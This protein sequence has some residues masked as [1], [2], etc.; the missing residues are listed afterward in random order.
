[1]GGIG[2]LTLLILVITAYCN[3]K[4]EF[5]SQTLVLSSQSCSNM[6]TVVIDTSKIHENLSDGFNY[7]LVMRIEN[8]FPSVEHTPNNVQFQTFLTYGMAH[9]YHKSSKS[10]LYNVSFAPWNYDKIELRQQFPR[11]NVTSPGD[12]PDLRLTVLM[13]GEGVTRDV[14]CNTLLR[15]S[16]DYE[17]YSLVKEAQQF[18]VDEKM[19]KKVCEIRC[20]FSNP[21]RIVVQQLLAPNLHDVRDTIHLSEFIGITHQ[22]VIFPCAALGQG[23][24]KA[25]A[26]NNTH[27]VQLEVTSYSPYILEDKGIIEFESKVVF[28]RKPKCDGCYLVFENNYH[29]FFYFDNIRAQPNNLKY[30]QLKNPQHQL[31]YFGTEG[32]FLI[33]YFEGVSLYFD[34]FNDDD[35]DLHAFNNQVN[36][37]SNVVSVHPI[38]TDGLGRAFLRVVVPPLVRPYDTFLKLDITH[39]ERMIISSTSVFFL[40]EK[41][42]KLK[43]LSLFQEEH[44]LFLNMCFSMANKESTVLLLIDNAQEFS[45]TL[46]ISFLLDSI[47]TLIVNEEKCSFFYDVGEEALFKVK[48]GDLSKYTEIKVR[49]DAYED[50]DSDLL[51]DFDIQFGIDKPI[52]GDSSC[53]KQYDIDSYTE[54]QVYGGITKT[55]ENNIFVIGISSDVIRSNSDVE[56]YITVRSKNLMMDHHVTV[57]MFMTEFMSEFVSISTVSKTLQEHSVFISQASGLFTTKHAS[58]EL[59][60]PFCDGNEKNRYEKCLKKNFGTT[61]PSYDMLKVNIKIDIPENSETPP[62]FIATW[63][64][65]KSVDTYENKAA[66]FGDGYTKLIGKTEKYEADIIVPYCAYKRFDRLSIFSDFSG[67]SFSANFTVSYQTVSPIKHVTKDSPIKLGY[68][69]I[70]LNVKTEKFREKVGLSI[71]N[72]CYN[73]LELH[74]VRFIDNLYYTVSMSPQSLCEATHNYRLTDRLS[75]VTDSDGSDVKFAVFPKQSYMTDTSGTTEFIAHLMLSNARLCPSSLEVDLPIRLV[76]N[77]ETLI[78]LLITPVLNSHDDACAISFR[79]RNIIADKN[80]PSLRVF[81]TLQQGFLPPGDVGPFSALFDMENSFEYP[82]TDSVRIIYDYSE[83]FWLS[84]RVLNNEDDGFEARNL[85]LYEVDVLHQSLSVFHHS[86]Q[87]NLTNIEPGEEISVFTLD[88]TTSAATFYFSEVPNNFPGARVTVTCASSPMNVIVEWKSNEEPYSTIFR[89]RNTFQYP[90]FR[91]D[92][93]SFAFDVVQKLNTGPQTMRFVNSG[94]DHHTCLFSLTMLERQRKLE[95]TALTHV[96][97]YFS[98]NAGLLRTGFYDIEFSFNDDFFDE[99]VLMAAIYTDTYLKWEEIAVDPIKNHVSFTN[100][101]IYEKDELTEVTLILC[102]KESYGSH[103]M[104]MKSSYYDLDAAKLS[105][106]YR[107]NIHATVVLGLNYELKCP[108]KPSLFSYMKVSFRDLRFKMDKFDVSLSMGGSQYSYAFNYEFD[109]QHNQIQLDISYGNYYLLLINYPYYMLHD[110]SIS[111]ECSDTVRVNVHDGTETDHLLKSVIA[112]ELDN[113][114]NEEIVQVFELNFEKDSNYDYSNIYYAVYDSCVGN[115]TYSDYNMFKPLNS[116]QSHIFL[117]LYRKH[118]DTK[119]VVLVGCFNFTICNHNLRLYIRQSPF[120][121][122]I[123]DLSFVKES[124]TKKI[125]LRRDAFV[126]H[127]F[128]STGHLTNTNVR[129]FSNRV[130][131][132]HTRSCAHVDPIDVSLL[133]R[134]MWQYYSDDHGLRCY[135]SCDHSIV[136]V[137]AEQPHDF[138]GVN[139]PGVCPFGHIDSDGEEHA[140]CEAVWFSFEDFGIFDVSQDEIT[141]EVQFFNDSIISNTIV[142]TQMIDRGRFTIASNTDASLIFHYST[143]YP[144]V[145]YIDTLGFDCI[146]PKHRLSY[147]RNEMLTATSFNSSKKYVPTSSGFLANVHVNETE[148]TEIEVEI[149]HNFRAPAYT[150]RF[151]RNYVLILTRRIDFVFILDFR[152]AALFTM[153]LPS[154][155]SKCTVLVKLNGEI[156]FPVIPMFDIDSQVALYGDTG[157]MWVFEFIPS[158]PC[159]SLPITYSFKEKTEVKVLQIGQLVDCIGNTCLLE[160]DTAHLLPIESLRLMFLRH[161]FEDKQ[162][163][164]FTVQIS[165][166]DFCDS[167]DG[168]TPFFVYGGKSTSCEVIHSIRST[169]NLEDFSVYPSLKLIREQFDYITGSDAGIEKKIYMLV[170]NIKFHFDKFNYF[171][172][173]FYNIKEEYFWN[174]NNAFY[175]LVYYFSNIPGYVFI[176]RL[177]LDNNHLD[178]IYFVACTNVYNIDQFLSIYNS[179]IFTKQNKYIQQDRSVKCY[180]G[181]QATLQKNFDRTDPRNDAG[182][183]KNR[184]VFSIREGF[185][186]HA[187]QVSIYLLVDDDVNSQISFKYSVQVR[188]SLG[189]IN[190]VKENYIFVEL[191]QFRTRK[192]HLKDFY[193]PLGLYNLFVDI[194]DNDQLNWSLNITDK[195]FDQS[196]KQL[197]LACIDPD[198]YIGFFAYQCWPKRIDADSDYNRFFS[199][200]D[201]FCYLRLS[202]LPSNDMLLLSGKRARTDI[203]AL[204]VKSDFDAFQRITYIIDLVDI[205]SDTINLFFHEKFPGLDVETCHRHNYAALTTKILNDVIFVTMIADQVGLYFTVDGAMNA[206]VNRVGNNISKIDEKDHVQPMYVSSHIT[207]VFPSMGDSCDILSYNFANIMNH[208]VLKAFHKDPNVEYYDITYFTNESL[209]PNK[210]KEWKGS[211]KTVEMCVSNNKCDVT[212]FW[213]VCS[214][215]EKANV[216]SLKVNFEYKEF[217]EIDKINAG[218]GSFSMDSQ[219]VALLPIEFGKDLCHIVTVECEGDC[220]DNVMMLTLDDDTDQRFEKTSLSLTE[221]VGFTG[222]AFCRTQSEVFKLKKALYFTNT[223]CQVNVSTIKTERESSG[224]TNWLE[225]LNWSMELIEI[226]PQS[227]YTVSLKGKGSAVVTLIPM[228]SAFTHRTIDNRGIFQL[229][230]KECDGLCFERTVG[231]K[232]SDTY[233]IVVFFKGSFKISMEDSQSIVLPSVIRK[234]LC[235]TILERLQKY[236]IKHLEV[237][238]VTH[239]FFSFDQGIESVINRKDALKELIMSV[240]GCPIVSEE[241]VGVL[242]EYSCLI[243]FKP[244]TYKN[245]FSALP[246]FLCLEMRD[247][248]HGVNEMLGLDCN[249]SAFV[250]YDLVLMKAS[251]IWIYVVAFILIVSIA[252]GLMLVIRKHKDLMVLRM[253]AEEKHTEKLS[254][255]QRF[256]DYVDQLDEPLLLDDF[257]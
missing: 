106:I 168:R 241:C 229:V 104:S 56:L 157:D 99:T 127:V 16:I 172:R 128:R 139:K 218:E 190:P 29:D 100:D 185:F 69:P 209:V 63:I 184:L 177:K 33:S 77:T 138:A 173:D 93:Y 90:S 134:Y 146:V 13:R 159:D 34:A 21:K 85:S 148:F 214:K 88:Y 116:T 27:L 253:L 147:I 217:N 251:E 228:N 242:Q 240:R 31:P 4:I 243:E 204:H 32:F 10:N 152:G 107:E 51:Q 2:F 1:M 162:N 150:I 17:V 8:L 180:I 5:G 114:N 46:V 98:L 163:S 54:R 193:N 26:Y 170:S 235:G 252:I 169:Q 102:L 194:D 155:T 250:Q 11:I 141:V 120:T 71:H 58:L 55:V 167:Q 191:E 23:I 12:A 15:Y 129:V 67:N 81:S 247:K 238:N 213:S 223:P 105:V 36:L 123:S 216:L 175:P 171:V 86:E 101:W 118:V 42:K 117:P 62:Y 189:E 109:L 232:M 40:D 84:F 158:G 53:L 89:M 208:G 75:I 82:S 124:L 174:A 234:D 76:V 142:T 70:I 255:R 135:K 18:T 156:L 137:S 215:T 200:S 166:Q 140:F 164:D 160:F 87:I 47:P 78:C 207:D 183:M 131:R 112:F 96:P 239:N 202:I 122:Q 211:L 219:E 161:Q 49:F 50:T 256:T 221:Q 244:L 236:Q 79:I 188:S 226:K 94:D 186:S 73:I 233:A 249:S 230:V 231:Q 144:P 187:D 45:E 126:W 37:T 224:N 196:T 43:K 95:T 14:H 111:I 136:S 60:F 222:Y 132:Y 206:H 61:N 38:K 35:I 20:L 125:V 151:D 179:D 25:Y 97:Q 108:E 80:L 145:L 65:H 130:V 153:S 59:L 192:F 39:T 41:G 22:S 103:S 133:Q 227:G 28:V 9:E 212:V 178:H 66:S 201:D 225:S 7:E 57:C 205:S 30:L 220:N 210:P 182:K 24:F 143:Q 115:C 121:V 154:R 248:C 72:Y 199:Q 257:E 203:L 176:V 198:E 245:Y 83:P 6:L 74:L 44:S 92:A 52:S 254:T 195:V 119:Y 3:N 165:V 237:L 68:E 246:K 19:A 113:N 48:L 64:R 181:Y 149:Q 197:Q 91:K 110:A